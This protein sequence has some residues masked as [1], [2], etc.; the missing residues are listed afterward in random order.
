MYK[1]SSSVKAGLASGVPANLLASKPKKPA[2]T[3]K[4]SG[5]P[6]INKPNQ[7][8]IGPPECS[9]SSFVLHDEV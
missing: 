4:L 6:S 7:I 8:A 1:V 5:I 3:T 2:P 9:S